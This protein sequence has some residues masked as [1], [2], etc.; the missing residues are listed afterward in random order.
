MN[1][2]SRIFSRQLRYDELSESI[3]EHMDEKI[4]DLM[5]DGLS[6]REAERAAR[7]AFGNVTRIEERSRE[8]WQWPTLESLWADVKFALRQLRK[9]PGFTLSVLLT[10]ALGIGAN[11]AV[12]SLV[13]TV[14]LHPLPYREPGRLMLVTESVP[15][16]GQDE[17]GVSIQEAQDYRNRTRTFAQM[18]TFESS[19]FNLTDAGEPQRVNAA[20]VSSSVFSLLG[21]A[22]ALGRTFDASEDRKG[23][24]R[25]V[26]LSSH[27]W[28][29][30][31]GG[32]AAIL[33]RAIKLDEMPYTVIGVMP[34]SFRFPFDGKALSE[35]A[36]VWV[37]DAIDASRLEPQN[38]LMEFGV[39]L[40]GR[41]R[42]GV[43]PVQAQAE[44][45]QIAAG[46]EAEHAGDYSGTLHV[47]PHAYAF[48]GYSM[49]KTRSLVVLLMAAVCCVLLISCANVANLLM[50][51]ASHRSREMAIR[52]AVG[53]N[54]ARLL[55]QCLV[56]SMVL[57]AG[58]AVLGLAV[59]EA[60]LNALRQWGPQSVPRLQDAAINPE[61]L[62]FTVG[63]M[64]STAILFGLIPAW[65]LSNVSP[66][67]AMKEGQSGAG[68]SGQLLLNL[69]AI[70]EVGLA[71]VLLI[72]GGLL[73]LTFVRLLE[74]PFGFD[75]RGTLVARTI[76]DQARYP[77]P[78]RRMVVQRELLDRL[79]H[80]PGI[81]SVAVA[82]H[83]PL[84]DERQIGIRLEHAAA[85]DFHWS[86]NSQ[87]SPGYLRTM[88]IALLEGR[89]FSEQDRAETVPVAVVSH[90]F[91]REY[92]SGLDPVGLRVYWGDRALFTIIGVSADVHLTALDANPPPMLYSSI[93]QV[94]SGASARAA[95]LLR[96]S[97]NQDARLPEI[98]KIIW[99]VDRDLPVYNATSLATLVEASLA[100]RRFTMQLL[101]AFALSAL[102][103]AMVGLFGVLSY[104]VEQ[105][106]RELGVRIALGADRNR[107]LA[108]VL[109]K[110]LMLGSI[111]CAVGLVLAVMSTGILRASLYHV[112]RFD[113]LILIGVPCLLLGVSLVSVWIPARRAASTDPMKALRAE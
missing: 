5:S 27:L 107:I 15:T 65:R 18:G 73:M 84:S 19:G 96:G 59:T 85:D 45:K 75:P 87:V 94:D 88:G 54:R 23:N 46:F 41:L 6:R 98:Q 92:L 81:E 31:Y 71:V 69:I 39:G 36:D 35:M 111:G 79:A 112:N 28:K 103:L 7:R 106:E 17:F 20:K 86:A 50:A 101:G 55:R 60:L 49:Q 30:K 109:R 64:L 34:P 43:E 104:L 89:D 82:T 110:G 10:L 99:S 102:V 47:Q 113:P 105:R 25:V 1:W 62:L 13:D 3:R 22:P 9:S 77:E 57:A 70:G 29:S 37:P 38:R 100:Q 108:M 33:G 21:V 72:G 51:R 90:E 44:M 68:R 4:S 61:V 67:T 48:A 78:A 24:D 11:I 14:L 26:V 83:L 56:E 97:G 53:A 91:A 2:L 74:T 42:P 76:F 95:F 40:I 80:L 52:A 66:Q 58:G 63:L 8:V 16:Q 32:D 12:F 93:F